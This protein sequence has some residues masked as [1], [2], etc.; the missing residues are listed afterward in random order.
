MKLTLLVIVLSLSASCKSTIPNNT[1]K[2]LETAI[3]P[4]RLTPDDIAHCTFEHRVYMT[5]VNGYKVVTTLSDGN[6]KTEAYGKKHQKT[7]LGTLTGKPIRTPSNLL[8]MTCGKGPQRYRINISEI[9]NAMFD[10]SDTVFRILFYGMKQ[11]KKRSGWVAHFKKN[12]LYMAKTLK[13]E[14]LPTVKN[15]CIVTIGHKLEHSKND[16]DIG[17]NDLYINKYSLVNDF[18]YS[19][20]LAR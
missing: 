18:P 2:D 20:R 10:G 14:G 5:Y 15:T 19:R 1:L 4:P 7:D 8:L 6:K 16:G 11:T 13:F 12:A 17:V 3:Q 9:K